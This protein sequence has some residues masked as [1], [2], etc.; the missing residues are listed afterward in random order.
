MASCTTVSCTPS[1]GK[2]YRVF[3]TPVEH[4]RLVCLTSGPHMSNSLIFGH[5]RRTGLGEFQ[6][7]GGWGLIVLRV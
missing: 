4:F 5:L 3:L 2:G 6:I 1:N 7:A